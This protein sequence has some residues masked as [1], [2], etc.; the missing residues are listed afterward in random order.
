MTYKK[1]LYLKKRYNTL[2]VVNIISKKMKYVVILGQIA[3]I[4][5]VGMLIAVSTIKNSDKG[6]ERITPCLYC[7]NSPM[8][9][10]ALFLLI[11]QS[12]ASSVRLNAPFL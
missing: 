1:F 5:L 3:I 6:R 8:Y 7:S 4:L 12:L 9:L 11:P 2:A 10:Y